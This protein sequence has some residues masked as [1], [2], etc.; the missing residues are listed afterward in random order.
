MRAELARR[1][2]N[3]TAKRAGVL[4]SLARD[5]RGRRIWHPVFLDFAHYWGFKPRL[6]RPYRAQTKGKIESGVRYVRRNFVCGLL[7]REPSCLADFNTQLRQWVDMVA[8]Q[9]VHG[10]T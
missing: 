1:G 7:G 3:L 8:N 5:F 9:R 10:T 2:C 6:C 4:A